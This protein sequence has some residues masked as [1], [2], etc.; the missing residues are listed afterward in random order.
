MVA[1]IMVEAE[2]AMIMVEAE[3]AMTMAEGMTVVVVTFKC[4][5]LQVV[6][7]VSDSMS[8]QTANSMNIR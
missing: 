6:R 5:P 3:V 7:V 8:T 2:V 4:L 1:V